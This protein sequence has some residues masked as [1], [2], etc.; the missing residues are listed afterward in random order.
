MCHVLP[1]HRHPSQDL[2]DVSHQTTVTDPLHLLI[3]TEKSR[4]RRTEAIF[5]R[6]G[7]IALSPTGAGLRSDIDKCCIDRLLSETSDPVP[8]WKLSSYIGRR[9]ACTRGG[10]VHVTA[11]HR[12]L[13]TIDASTRRA[14]GRTAAISEI[15]KVYQECSGEASPVPPQ[16]QHLTLQ[17]TDESRTRARLE[18]LTGLLWTGRDTGHDH[19]FHEV[20]AACTSVPLAS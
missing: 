9:M 8:S 4:K 1:H 12:P 5:L 15:C 7:T 17:P 20:R 14:R 19:R 18:T 16:A 6:Q 3:E 2:T 13:S 10:D 11:A